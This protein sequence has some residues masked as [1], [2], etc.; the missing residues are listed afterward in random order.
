MNTI[1]VPAKVEELD[2]VLDFLKHQLTDVNCSAEIL[3]QVSIAAEEIFVNIAHYAYEPDSGESTI[4]CQVDKEKEP[5]QVTIEFL[6][7]GIPYDPL[8]RMDP[9]VTL[10]AEA[11]DIGGLGIFM[12][13][14]MM[15]NV[16]YD[17]RD[18]KN[19]LTLQK[20]VAPSSKSHENT[21]NR[22][23]SV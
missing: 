9:D 17:Y 4:R 2:T 7:S 16:S 10:S 20:N 22:S 23:T 11:R 5:I 8:S 14:E 19:I 6:D 3:M 12:V 15:D 21:S 18:G 13:K 1:T